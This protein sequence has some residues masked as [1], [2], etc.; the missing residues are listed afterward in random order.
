MKKIEK[1]MYAVFILGFGVSFL[2]ATENKLLEKRVERAVT[3]A[4]TQV[5]P[6]L[7]DTAVVDMILKM[8][9]AWKHPLNDYSSTPK[10]NN[11]PCSAVRI[12][13]NWLMAS[14][15]CRGVGDF[16]TAFDHNGE[17]YIK[18]VK[19]RKVLH[20]KIRSKARHLRDTIPQR[21][22]FVNED[23]Q[24]ILLR[25]DLSN[26][27]L[28]EEVADVKVAPLLISQNPNTIIQRL[29]KAF[30]NR[31]RYMQ[32]G[33]C[34]SCVGVEKYCSDT[35][36]YQTKGEWILGDSSDPLFFV[37]QNQEFLVGFNNADIEG[38]DPLSSNLYR[39]FSSVTQEALSSILREQDPAA[40][41]RIQSKM[42]SS[43]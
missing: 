43:L 4:T 26:K 15:K 12:D 24:I 36:C 18:E 3:K 21:N 28:K 11:K 1:L 34:S 33:R 25:L 39:A 20:A 2:H 35:Q 8:E 22:I 27:D 10:T 9:Y 7:H 42:K 41:K 16:A 6:D 29:Y 31:E 32:V 17:P 13:Q 37:K 30:I 23:A 19:Y 40:L 38:E 14:L 5:K